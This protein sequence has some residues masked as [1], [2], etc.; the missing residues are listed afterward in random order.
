M[1]MLS[2]ILWYI[3]N[4]REIQMIFTHLFLFM[5]SSNIFAGEQL[6]VKVKGMVCSFCSQGITKKFKEQSA[7]KD[8]NVNLDNHLVT[9]NLN[10]GAQLDDVTVTKILKDSGYSV[11]KIERK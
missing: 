5:F 3:F 1:E 9:M 2:L 6:N 11:E 8:V 7:V 4:D 10:D